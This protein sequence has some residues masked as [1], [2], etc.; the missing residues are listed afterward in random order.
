M[1]LTNTSLKHYFNAS[2]SIS[3]FFSILATCSV[4]HTASASSCDGKTISAKNPGKY[5]VLSL[6]YTFNKHVQ[7]GQPVL[8]RRGNPIYLIKQI[9][10]GD[11]SEMKT[12][13]IKEASSNIPKDKCDSHVGHSYNLVAEN[14]GNA[15]GYF[16]Y[17]FED[18]FCGWADSVCTKMERQKVGQSPHTRCEDT[19]ISAWGMKTK[20]IPKCTVYWKDNFMHVPV[21]YPCKEKTKYKNYQKT[22]T[23]NTIFTPSLDPETKTIDINGSTSIDDRGGIPNI[24]LNTVGVLTLNIGSKWMLDNYRATLSQIEADFPKINEKIFAHIPDAAPISFDMS[25]ARFVNIN[26]SVGLEVS[27]TALRR[28]GEACFLHDILVGSDL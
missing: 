9:S 4:A 15:R 27:S 23:V 18:W 19:W 12:R 7:N 8:D 26:H 14:N 16:S 25:G 24:I 3:L 21:T 10:V 13:Y 11:A 1:F 17:R 28:V 22:V 2:K 6:R 5:G 20:G